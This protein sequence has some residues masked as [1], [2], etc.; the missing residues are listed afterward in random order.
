LS[1]SAYATVPSGGVALGVVEKDLLIIG[2][3]G[4]IVRLR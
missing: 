4:Q 2:A 3:N 1:W